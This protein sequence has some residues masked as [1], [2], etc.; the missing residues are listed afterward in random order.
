MKKTEN[1]KIKNATPLQ[2]DNIQFKSKLEVMAYKTLKEAGFNPQYELE[3]F[4][5]WEGFK[6]TVP[7]YDKDKVTRLLKPNNKKMVN[8]TYSPDFMFYYKEHPI[9][10]ELKGM[11]NDTFPLKKKLFRAYLESHLPNSLYFEIFSKR[12]LLQA[13]QIIKSL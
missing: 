4:V 13:I 12:Q 8:I 11:E 3:K 2:Y 6:P 9:I 5:L 10:V 7:F 1:K